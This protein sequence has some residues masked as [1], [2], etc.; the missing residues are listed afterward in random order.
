MVLNIMCYFFSETRCIITYCEDDKDT[1]RQRDR[2]RD[3]TQI[4]SES[5]LPRSASS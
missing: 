4:K 3:D 5:E 2:E 1:E